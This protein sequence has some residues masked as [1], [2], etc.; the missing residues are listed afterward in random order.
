MHATPRFRWVYCQFDFLRG[1]LPARIRRAISELPETLDA[2]YE[3]TLR[4]MKKANWEFAHRLLQCVAVASRP[5]RVEELAEFLAF[6]FETGPIPEFDEEL[7]LEDPVDAVLST[8]SSLVAVVNVKDYKAI[9]FS[10]FSVKEYLTS[11]RLA[12]S[13]ENLSR[14]YHVSMPFAH[15]LVAQACL[16]ILL[17]LDNGI[18]RDSLRKFPLAEYAAEHWVGHAL[19][20][21]V[22]RNV[23]GG[24]KQLFDPRKAHLGIWV[25]IFDPASWTRR[26][27]QRAETPS[28]SGGKSLHY[29]AICG[30]ESI[31][32]FLVVEHSQDVHSRAFEEESTPLHEA[33]SRGHV[34]VTRLLLDCGADV[35]AQDK[36]V[37]TP[38]HRASAE[39]H[40]DLVRILFERGGDLNARDNHGYAP[41]LWASHRGQV[42]AAHV[43]LECGADVMARGNIG[44]AP[45]FEAVNMGHV[46]TARVL[47]KSGA[48][49]N[50]QDNNGSTP[51]HRASLK[52]NIEIT[53]LLLEY[54]AD[55][56]AK[57]LH[58]WTPLHEVSYRGYTEIARLFLKSGADVNARN[59]TG[60]T[61]LNRASLLEHVELALLLLEHGADATAKCVKG[62][63]PLHYASGARRVGT[64]RVLLECGVNVKAQNNEG[65]T[66]LDLVSEE[67]DA[68]LYNILREAA[69]AQQQRD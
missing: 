15:A 27:V 62:S 42:E 61:P 51:L 66:P 30:L 16:G 48:N 67:R 39:G 24:M 64:T 68:E 3:R 22:S 44:N 19:F 69:E 37:W 25:W 60:L 33:A 36:R 29:A 34:G 59:D 8:C 31:V 32:T 46:E 9:Q 28:R 11:S 13:S 7:R 14:Q 12:E 41:L 20:G 10:H 58:S 38:L 57:N 23:E 4:D 53:R 6:D 45:L 40:A 50:A 1:C 56:N 55:V 35:A 21:G 17:H 52:G 65:S 54:D 26:E 47:L 5:L 49:A 63:T 43:L 2:T 18:T